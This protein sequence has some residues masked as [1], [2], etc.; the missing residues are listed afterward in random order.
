MVSNLFL[1][2]ENRTYCF[3]LNQ[4]IHKSL[5]TPMTSSLHFTLHIFPAVRR[6]YWQVSYIRRWYRG[7]GGLATLNR[8]AIWKPCAK[9][10]RK[11]ALL[12]ATWRD[13]STAPTLII[14]PPSSEI[15]WLD[16]RGPTQRNLLRTVRAFPVIF[17]RSYKRASGFSQNVVWIACVLSS[18]S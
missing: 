1:I 7:G 10:I 6:V 13:S 18:V 8:Y 3:T 11:I 9:T 12:R 2:M 5:R 4:L 16:K 15:F 14:L 17:R